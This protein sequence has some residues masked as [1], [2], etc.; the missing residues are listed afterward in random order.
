MSGMRKY[1]N[2]YQILLGVIDAIPEDRRMFLA[3]VINGVTT[4]TNTDPNTYLCGCVIGS[5]A[6]GA[7]PTSGESTHV[8]SMFQEWDPFRCWAD[9][10]GLPFGPLRNV[11]IINDGFLYPEGH[12]YNLGGY[13]SAEVCRQRYEHVRA[14]VAEKARE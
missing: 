4:P 8:T 2:P 14:Y 12:G 1:V 11:Q 3:G 9:S 13:N 5:I 10:Q 7:T 6:Q